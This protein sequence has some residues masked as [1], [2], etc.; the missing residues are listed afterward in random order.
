MGSFLRRRILQP[1]LDLLT[2]GITPEK[3]ALSL[4]IGLAIGVFPM[5]GVTTLLCALI[6]VVLKL[7]LPTIQLVN[8][9]VYPAQIAL[10]I[11]FIRLGE[12]LSGAP[13]LPLSVSQ[14]LAMIKADAWHAITFLWHSTMLAVVGWCLTAPFF[15]VCFYLAALPILR[16]ASRKTRPLPADFKLGT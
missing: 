10:L 15:I 2:Q 13:P 7:N 14:I 11:P 8:Y 6:A 12:K 9:L 16:Y 4:A 1:I 3:I 5:L